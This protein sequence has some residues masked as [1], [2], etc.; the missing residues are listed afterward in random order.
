MFSFPFSDVQ[1]ILLDVLLN[2][3]LLCV[4]L[5]LALNAT[6]TSELS[7]S[8][9]PHMSPNLKYDL[10]SDHIKHHGVP[11]LSSP[12]ASLLAYGVPLPGTSAPI[13]KSSSFSSALS[14]R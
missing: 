3:T 2:P 4:L 8:L 5:G 11:T 10:S 7:P 6:P 13:S 1:Q 9:L 14:S 12:S